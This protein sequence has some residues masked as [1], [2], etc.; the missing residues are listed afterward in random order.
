MYKKI[1]HDNY[2]DPEAQSGGQD[3]MTKQP[4]S[5]DA[6]QPVENMF[7]HMQLVIPPLEKQVDLN[8][9]QQIMV[10]AYRKN[11]VRHCV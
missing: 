11:P 8:K 2:V 4:N 1:F 6:I 7:D 5:K 10:T 9:R 3:P